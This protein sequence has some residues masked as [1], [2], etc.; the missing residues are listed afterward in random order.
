MRCGDLLTHSPASTTRIE[1]LQKRADFVAARAGGYASGAFVR[2]QARHREAP[3]HARIGYT[4][5]KKNGNAVVRNRIKRRLRAAI[6]TIDPLL[7]QPDRDYVVISKPQALTADFAALQG[8]LASAIARA[9]RK[10][11]QP[12]RNET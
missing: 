2:V 1:T 5:T 10:S 12:S 11:Q 6:E 4:V 3:L 9:T 7:I 8:D